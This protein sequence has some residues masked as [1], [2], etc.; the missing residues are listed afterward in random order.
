MIQSKYYH[1][2]QGPPLINATL[3]NTRSPHDTQDITPLIQ[4]KYGT[5]HNWNG[6]LYTYYDIF[7]PECKG[8]NF[9]CDFLS[10]DGRKHWFY[11]TIHDIQQYFN[12]PLAT[13]FN[14]KKI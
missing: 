1:S 7:G 2:Y 3:S 13:P 8:K 14:L 4:E 11:G 12:P 5:D 9:K 6:Y 10:K